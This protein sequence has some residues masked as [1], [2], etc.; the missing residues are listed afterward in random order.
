[1]EN[2]PE[3]D[4]DELL[5]DDF[6]LKYTEERKKQ[7][8]TLSFGSMQEISL[9]DYEKQV[10]QASKNSWVIVF[11]YQNYINICQK[12]DSILSDLAARFHQIKFVKIQA[13]RC[14]P[15]KYF[16][17]KKDYPDK[18]VPT[19]ILYHEENVVTQLVGSG[20]VGGSGLSMEKM[21]HTLR[22]FGVPL[23]EQG[24]EQSE[25][26]SDDESENDQ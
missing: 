18:N 17:L 20:A 19:I 21:V 11:L 8:Q 7:L 9:P 2:D 12:L 26:H 13:T 3:E 10:T 24:R 22:S 23:Y 5:N 15:S 16:K 14:I 25:E 6:I 1:V 4:L